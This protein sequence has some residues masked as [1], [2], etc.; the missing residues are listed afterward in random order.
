MQRPYQLHFKQPVIQSVE[1]LP[2]WSR[3]SFRAAR[4]RLLTTFDGAELSS[5]WLHEPPFYIEL[6]ESRSVK[7]LRINYEILEKK[8]FLFFMTEGPMTF[9]TPGG[10]YASYARNRHFALISNDQARYVSHF[11]A[12]YSSGFSIFIDPDWLLYFSQDQQLLHS[13]I[14][15]EHSLGYEVLPSCYIDTRISSLLK[16]LYSVQVRNKGVLDGQLRYFISM[17]LERYIQMAL[18]KQQNLSWRLKKYLDQNF[19]DPTISYSNLST[20]FNESERTLRYHFQKEQGISMHQLLTHKRLQFAHRLIEHEG[21]QI[22]DVYLRAGYQDES[23]FRRA[24]RNFFL[25]QGK[26]DV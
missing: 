1:G 4:Q 8:Y 9:T 22:S 16:K 12:G 5:Q 25:S 3:H 14:F 7:N 2:A 11:P 26:S 21:K 23:T 13:F 20:L 6:F 17:I 24:Y 10:F 15:K 19:S 18:I